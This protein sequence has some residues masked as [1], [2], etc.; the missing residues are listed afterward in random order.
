MKRE[1][2]RL[3]IL[4]IYLAAFLSLHQVTPNLELNNGRVNFIFPST[5]QVNKLITVY[6]RNAVVPVAD[7]AV[8]IKTLRGQMFAL[9]E[10]SK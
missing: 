10:R 1:E 4:D 8:A 6:N 9:K 2:Q 7:F 3:T 5:E